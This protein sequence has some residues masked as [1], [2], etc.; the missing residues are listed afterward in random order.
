MHRS[1]GRDTRCLVCDRLL[2]WL[3]DGCDWND[4]PAELLCLDCGRWARQALSS[5]RGRAQA[6]TP[7]PAMGIFGGSVED[8]ERAAEGQSNGLGVPLRRLR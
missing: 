4:L 1:G 8:L 6:W 7:P 3:Q 2:L 5:G